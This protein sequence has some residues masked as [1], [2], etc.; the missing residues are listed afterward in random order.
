MCQSPCGRLA[1]LVGGLGRASAATIGPSATLAGVARPVRVGPSRSESSSPRG[2]R[3]LWNSQ[4]P[5]RVPASPAVAW[6]AP[7]AALLVHIDAPG[8]AGPVGSR[9]HWQ[10]SIRV[11][12]SLQACGDCSTRVLITQRPAQGGAALSGPGA[13]IWVLRK[14]QRGLDSLR[15]ALHARTCRPTCPQRERLGLRSPE[16]AASGASIIMVLILP[17]LRFPGISR[18]PAEERRSNK[19][20]DGFARAILEATTMALQMAPISVTELEGEANRSE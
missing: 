9:P 7:R 2:L 13:R 3:T 4:P 16:S 10:D 6:Y 17:T 5:F 8:P 14:S 12:S 11:G 20:I 15:R 18:I 19:G 1:V